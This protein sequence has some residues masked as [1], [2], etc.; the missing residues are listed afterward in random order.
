MA[1]KDLKELKT[2]LQ[3]FLDR[4]FIRPSVSPWGAPVLFVKKKDGT[5]RMCI[6]Y[7]QLNKLTIKNKYPLPRIDD[8]FD[9]FRGASVF[10]MIDLRSGYYQLKVKDV[11]VPKTAF[12]TRCEYY[13]FLVMSFGL[14]NA[15]AAFMDMMNRVFHEFLDQ[16]V[17]VF[18]DD[19]LVYSRTEDNHDR[20]LRIVLQALLE[21]QLYAKLS[22][23]EFWLREVVFLGHVVSAE[24]I[25]V[26][27]HKVEAV[28]S[29]KVPKSVTEVRSFLGFAGYYRRFVEGFSKIAAPLTKLLQK[30]VCFEWTDARQQAFEKLKEALTQAL[31][32]IQLES[33]KEFVVYSDASI[34]GLGCVLIQEGKV[35]AYASR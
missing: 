20:H 25:N 16:F 1:P 35:V 2:Q 33:G 15:P 29:W 14:T 7:R 10:S 28:M 6:D 3:E 27:P 9:Q 31:V 12:R 34:V 5:M 23:C 18:I 19:I 13:E 11:D 24:G 21:N 26:D 32:L 4:G 30:N 8:L 22:K 17:V